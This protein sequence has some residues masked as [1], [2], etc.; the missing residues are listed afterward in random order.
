LWNILIGEMSL[1]G[2]RPERPEFVSMLERSIPSY[3]DRL[4][5]RPGLTGLAQVR[6]P[7]DTDVGGVH[8]KLTFDLH[9]IRECNLWLDLRLL[10]CT[11]LFLMG[12]PFRLSSRLLRIPDREDVQAA[13]RSAEPSTHRIALISSSATKRVGALNSTTDVFG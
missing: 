12:M 3:R 4:V 13:R 5:I 9:Y 6:L 2:P 8:D 11:A 1:V 10:A 7:A